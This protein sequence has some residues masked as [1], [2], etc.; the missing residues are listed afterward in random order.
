M[1]NS[2]DGKRTGRARGWL[3]AGLSVA[4][5]LGL[6]ALKGKADAS[7]TDLDSN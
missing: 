7:D 6:A 3:V 5:L 4:L 1:T 2:T